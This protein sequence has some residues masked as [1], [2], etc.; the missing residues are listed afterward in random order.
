M[1]DQSDHRL[2]WL[3]DGRV[4]IHLGAPDLGQGLATVAE[5]ITAESLGLPFD[6]V[7][8]S[9]FDTSD[10]PDGG[11]CCA[12]RMT[13]LVGNAMIKGAKALKDQLLQ[14]AGSSSR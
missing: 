9:D 10:V 4:L 8:T 1:T 11:V 14:S 3:P 6:R 7:I 12:S 2:E 13:Y 5:Q